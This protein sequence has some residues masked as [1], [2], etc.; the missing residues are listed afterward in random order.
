MRRFTSVMVLGL[1]AFVGSQIA[2]CGVIQIPVPF[3]LN[4]DAGG[5]GS[6]E[7]EAD[8]PST[9]AFTTNFDTS[10]YTVGSGSVVL[11]PDD[12]TVTPDSNAPGKF[13]PRQQS[14]S[15]LEITVTIGAATWPGPSA[16]P[17]WGRRTVRS[18]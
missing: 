11:D 18:A 1:V 3:E 9:N 12:I 16:T 15:V 6:F 2:G 13:A 5:N 7:V 4:T 14:T 10:Q 8:T 17:G